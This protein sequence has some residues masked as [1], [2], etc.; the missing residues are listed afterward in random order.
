MA[1]RLV[2]VTRACTPPTANRDHKAKA[3]SPPAAAA[4]TTASSSKVA[5]A[6]S[7]GSSGYVAPAVDVRPVGPWTEITTFALDLGGYNKPDISIDLRLKGVESLAA[8][9]VTCDFKEDSFDLKVLG[10]DGKNHRFVR[11]NLEKDIVPAESSI[12]VKKNHVI[13]TLR[14]VK[15]EYGYDSW[16]DLCAKGKRKPTASKSENPQDSIMSMMKDL[17]DEGDDNMKKIIGEAMYKA[18]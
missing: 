4:A 13:I 8:E 11:T 2:L 6:A 14:K 12:K 15:G 18:R 16:T 17:Y 9:N 3:E 10:L 7:Q 1:A 5:A